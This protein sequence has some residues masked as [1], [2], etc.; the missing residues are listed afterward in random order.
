MAVIMSGCLLMMENKK[1]KAKN[2]VWFIKNI[3]MPMKAGMVFMIGRETFHMFME[4]TWITDSGTSCYITNDDTGLF[5][6]TEIQ[7][8]IQGSLD[9]MLTTKKGKLGINI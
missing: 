5:E 6:A 1:Q 8:L 2:E 9:S 4:N 3:K 7:E